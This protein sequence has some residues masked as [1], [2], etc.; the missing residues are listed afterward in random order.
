MHT[1]VHF[2][3]IKDSIGQNNGG[4]FRMVQK[5]VNNLMQ[6]NTERNRIEIYTPPSM[7]YPFPLLLLRP[8]QAIQHISA[9]LL[10]S[11][12]ENVFDNFVHLCTLG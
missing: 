11:V 9:R 4:N 12:K 10:V 3:S 8:L 1:A 5:V 2:C 7:E 6:V